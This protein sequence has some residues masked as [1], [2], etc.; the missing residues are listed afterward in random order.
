MTD[1]KLKVLRQI[2]FHIMSVNDK[3]SWIL[4]LVLINL[5]ISIA[6]LVWI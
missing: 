2:K 1:N 5:F 3:V 6:R 4:Y